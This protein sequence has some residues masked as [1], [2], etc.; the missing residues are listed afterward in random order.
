M[1][2]GTVTRCGRNTF[3][4][5]RD[6]DGSVAS[7]TYSEFDAIVE[8]TALALEGRGVR[9][10]DAVHLALKNSPAFVALWLATA[11]IGAWM[12]TVDPASTARDLASQIQRTKPVLGFCASSRSAPYREASVGL[13]N[14]I[15]ELH[16]T[17]ADVTD[18]SVLV[19]TDKSATDEPPT[20]ERAVPA[21][22]DRMALMFTSGTTSA[23][24]GV[25][26]TQ[27]NY[28]Y[29]SQMMS[30]LIDLQPRHRWLVTLPLFHGNAQFY[31]FG[32]AI[33]VGASVA[34]TATFSASGWV[35]QAHQLEATHA[36]LFAAPIRMI[37][38]RNPADAPALSLE[39]VW[40]AQSLGKLHYAE[41][42]KI[43]GCSPR[44][45]YGMTE[46]TAVV[47]ADL[48]QRP[49]HD[50]IGAALPLRSVELRDRLTGERVPVG[51]PGVITLRGERGVD[52][53]D[54]YLDDPETT[55]RAMSTV[56][57]ETWLSTG[58]LAVS[59]ASGIYRFVGRIDDVIK[60]AGENV[61]LTE[62]E[63]ALAQAPG[64]LEVAVLA[65]PDP[66]RDQVPVAFVVPRD[67]AN[68]PSP[69]DLELWAAINLP[70]Q[71]RPREWSVIDE[72]PRTSV[73]K[74]RRFQLAKA[75]DVATPA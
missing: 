39:H 22:R 66:I 74:I 14:N 61:S 29:V 2:A 64:I 26:L 57:T 33:A 69:A 1:W 23:P 49:G 43:V 73:G 20:T 6:S 12:V 3:L 38:A 59:N 27:R 65:K 7:W 35:S 75:I 32:P 4:V 60:V 68:P 15:A 17:A 44:Q 28:H 11:K 18:D 46:T 16:E 8:R 25:V 55:D 47:T 21:G 54:G 34:L 40:F 50:I 70:P 5:Y 52:L 58:D 71:S 56:G 31:C 10:G 42:E 72:L 19:R 41:F 9:R 63:A 37:I 45:L 13:L 36:S 62:I 67:A 30:S 51:K 53:F 48:S 24:K